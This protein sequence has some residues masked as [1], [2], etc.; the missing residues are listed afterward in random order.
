MFVQKLIRKLIILSFAILNFAMFA[1]GVIRLGNSSISGFQL[2]TMNASDSDV[3]NFLYFVLGIVLILVAILLAIFAIIN[4]F[5]R[6]NIFGKVIVVFSII[7]YSVYFLVG[8]SYY[9][10]MVNLV[11][12]F[13]VFGA[14]TDAYWPLVIGIVLAIGHRIVTGLIEKKLREKNIPTI[15]QPEPVKEVV[16]IKEEVKTVSEPVTTVNKDV[17]ALASLAKL[18]EQGII[19]EEEYNEKKKK[20]CE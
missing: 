9:I 16:V 13:A 18:K 8:L 12:D 4:M 11:P 3:L 17:E 14:T 5:A 10:V 6:K 1:F 7:L 15:V 19:T 20:I 2:I